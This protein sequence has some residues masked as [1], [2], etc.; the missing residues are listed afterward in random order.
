MRRALDTTRLPPPTVPLAFL[1]AAP[2]FGVAAG[3]VVAWHGAAVVASRWFAP[4][5]AAVHLV[6][7]G[8]LTMT[9]AGSLLQMIPA[10]AGLPLRGT[11][12][13]AAWSC[14]LLGAGAALLAAA[15]LSGH[16][17]LFALAGATLLAAFGALLAC[18]V[19]SLWQ[20]TRAAASTAHIAGGMRA[21]VAALLACVGAGLL[22]AGW[23]AGGPAV[24]VLPLVDTHAAL[25]LAGWV[26]PLVM[27]V[28][29]QVI[30]MFQ[31]TDPFPPPAARVLA[32]LV[33]LALAGW[34]AGRWLDAPWRAVPALAGAALVTAYAGLA[35]AL[36]L[37]RERTRTAAGTRYWLL[38]LASLTA[39]AWMFAWPGET[40][41]ALVGVCFLAG[42]AMSAVNGM[43]YRIVPFLVW[44]QLRARLPADVA[45]PKFAELI[46]PD[47]LRT[48]CRWH[49]AAVAVLVAACVVPP[50][51]S[52]AG[53]LLAIAC[54]RL[55]LDLAAPVMRHRLSL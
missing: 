2:W 9:M 17:L 24:P 41:D 54:L 53:V 26:L 38:S 7:L 31:A 25:G 4:A 11:W 35:A 23:L 3:V 36:L 16:A 40:S 43:L 51:A 34:I 20:R 32:P 22:L 21:A 14:P 18:L 29:F 12:R 48:Q 28:S 33:L 52:V 45:V 30:P 1:L 10:V 46:A 39:A 15:F 55:G 47:R 49:G 19:P 6:T 27:A 42:C 13:P 8:F 37:R 44:H 5:L 50:L